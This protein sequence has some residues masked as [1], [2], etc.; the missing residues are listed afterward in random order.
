MRAPG[1]RSGRGLELAAHDLLIDH[2]AAVDIGVDPGEGH[3]EVH[4]SRLNGLAPGASLGETLS[5]EGHLAEVDGGH[6]TL[7]PVV[8]EHQ[9]GQPEL[10]G[11]EVAVLEDEV[12]HVGPLVEVLGQ[13]DDLVSLAIEGPLTRD[14]TEGDTEGPGLVVGVVGGAQPGSP[15]DL[16]LLTGLGAGL[17]LLGVGAQ[18][19]DHEQG[20]GDGAEDGEDELARNGHGVSP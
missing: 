5:P 18:G 13:A 14:A 19:H 9:G 11:L 10:V 16:D 2:G 7:G 1:R 12:N 4:H 6:L 15:E 3:V 8:R 17:G 20:E